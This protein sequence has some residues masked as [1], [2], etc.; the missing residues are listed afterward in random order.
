MFFGPTPK[1]VKNTYYRE[2]TK[3]SRKKLFI[4]RNDFVSET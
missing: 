4:F 3:F 2:N 1:N